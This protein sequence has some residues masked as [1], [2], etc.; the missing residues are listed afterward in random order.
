M[1][2]AIAAFFSMFRTIFIAGNE[3][4]NAAHTSAKALNKLAQVGE[5][6][7]DGLQ[8]EAQQERT[9]N[10]EKFKLKLA[11]AKKNLELENNTF[12]LEFANTSKTKQ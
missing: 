2:D 3:V 9:L 6:M 8:D 10:Q 12:E 7:A 5:I 1:R 11:K 4:A